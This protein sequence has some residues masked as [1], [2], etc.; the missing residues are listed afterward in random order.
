M[1]I[2]I[3]LFVIILVIA[4]ATY[5]IGSFFMSIAIVRSKHS[6][7]FV[8]SEEQEQRDIKD[9]KTRE[10]ER[11]LIESGEVFYQKTEKEE[12]EIKSRDGLCLKASF[13]KRDGNR[14]AILVHGYTGSRKEIMPS[15]AFFYNRGYSVLAPDNRA[16]GESEG[17]YIGMGALDKDDIASWCSWIREKKADARIVL[18]GI[19]MGGATVMMVSGDAIKGV[20]AVIDDC[21]YTSVWDIFCDELHSLYHLPTFPILDMCRIMIRIKAHY[22][23]K[24]ASSVEQL[25]KAEV[26]VLFIHGADDHFVKTEMVYKCF[27]AKTN[28]DK[29]LLIVKGAGHGESATTAPDLYYGKIADFLSHYAL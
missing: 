27:D 11:K 6:N 10:R 5:A 14:F 9:E 24:K 1:S 15:A 25:R 18:L 7:S 21:G 13:F 20:E 26:P 8:P 3:A 19:S 4:V 29:D 17:K 2:L 28:G 23:I 12:V 16:H 22:D